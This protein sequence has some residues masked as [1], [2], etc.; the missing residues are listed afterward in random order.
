LPLEIQQEA[1]L[2]YRL[3]RASPA[4]PSLHFKKV[5]GESDIYS[6]RIGLDYRALAVLRG[7]RVVW[8]WI[9]G[10]SEYDWLV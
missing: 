1:K 7:D 6:A 2:A 10:H 4:H 8:Y 5:E 9:G 3:V